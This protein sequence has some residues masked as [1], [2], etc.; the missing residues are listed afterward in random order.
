M[1]PTPA[2]PSDEGNQ[3]ET[4][5]QKALFPVV[6]T[7][8]AMVACSPQQ[9]PSP[10]GTLTG[11]WLGAEPG[12]VKVAGSAANTTTTFD[13]T[14]RGISNRSADAGGTGLK[15]VD[16]YRA[17]CQQFEEPPT[18]TIANGL[19]QFKALDVT[20]AGYVTPQ[21]HLKMDSGYG[22]AVEADFDPQ[23]HILRGRALSVNCRYD[24]AWQ[25][26]T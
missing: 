13:G 14:Y 3:R 17:G 21:G 12:A 16:P 23:T 10:Q 26:I 9:P 4:A 6:I 1:I 7:L 24:V 11:H 22:P 19:A 18:L 25:K 2:T 8:L 5:M 20:F 15:A